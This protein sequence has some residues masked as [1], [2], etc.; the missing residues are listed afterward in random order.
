MADYDRARANS[1]CPPLPF[2]RATIFLNVIESVFRGI[3]LAQSISTNSD[4]KSV[5]ERRPG[6]SSDSDEPQRS[7]RHALVI[8][9]VAVAPCAGLTGQHA[10][11]TAP[12]RQGFRWHHLRN[13]RKWGGC[14]VG[15]DHAR[16]QIDDRIDRRTKPMARIDSH[17]QRTSQSRIA[18]HCQWPPCESRVYGPG[19]FLNRQCKSFCKQKN[20]PERSFGRCRGTDAVTS[21]PPAQILH[22]T[23]S[24]YGLLLG[25]RTHH[26]R[27]R[28]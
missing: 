13:A 7:Q 6:P 12:S 18:E 20:R 16:P 23:I 15:P 5:N 10:G 4:Y 11:P 24:S 27:P 22:R 3:C 2:Q 25:C 28:C 17:A 26:Q 19:N 8:A 21:R 1:A 14:S 9:L